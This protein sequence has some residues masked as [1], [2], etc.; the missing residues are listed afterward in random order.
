VKLRAMLQTPI[1]GQSVLR[2]LPWVIIIF[3][4]G[5][6]YAQ[7]FKHAETAPYYDDYPAIF[8]FLI[9]FLNGGVADKIS[10]FSAL[11]NEHRPAFT[12][13]VSL[14]VYSALGSVDMRVLLFIGNLGLLALAGI[15]Y[16]TFSN[17]P[18]KPLYF[19]PVV[20]ALFQPQHW[21]NMYWT[22]ASLQNF[23]V[24]VFSFLCLYFIVKPD[25][26]LA[27]ALFCLL[28]VFTS[29]NGLLL[30]P[31]GL[32]ALR[33]KNAATVSIWLALGLLI[34]FA[35]FAGY[36]SA[37][38]ELRGLIRPLPLVKFF[39]CFLGSGFQKSYVPANTPA[40]LTGLAFV[41]YFAY[42]TVARYYRKNPAVYWFTFFLFASSFLAS[43]IRSVHG[44]PTPIASRYMIYSVL[45]AVCFYT[46]ICDT[47]KSGV[48]KGILPVILLFAFIFNLWSYTVNRT[49]IIE[50]NSDRESFTRNCPGWHNAAEIE[51][52]A[53]RLKLIQ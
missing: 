24:L 51:S 1:T 18:G 13:I 15:L 28:A 37:G 25:G 23:W 19:L 9:D 16:R 17:Q 42:L 3:V 40:L 30:I 29:G 33:R 43:V 35:Y 27:A 44:I 48:V 6:F 32:I 11:F 20:F 45:L 49:H 41:L 53:I 47:Q 52:E 38:G 8:T 46:A 2:L 22:M 34:V 21:E 39:L 36:P 50:F 4:V 26:L 31:I 14:A 5:F 10:A 7:I 12:R